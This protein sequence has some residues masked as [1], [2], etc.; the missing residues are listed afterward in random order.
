MNV[1]KFLIQLGATFVSAALGNLGM[2]QVLG[3]EEWKAALMSGGYVVLEVI[4]KLAVALRDGSL[5]ED[6]A[7]D[8]FVAIEL[9]GEDQ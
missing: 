6:E 8:L 4:R 2:A 1:K 9:D 5:T 7:T 3:V